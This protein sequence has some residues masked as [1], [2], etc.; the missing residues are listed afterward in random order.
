MAH[1][2]VSVEVNPMAVPGQKPKPHI[3]AVREGT[4]RPDRNS[5]GARIAVAEPT[6]PDW[7]ELLPPA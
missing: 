4:Y 1:Q 6:E 3:Q 7:D 5:E 2:S